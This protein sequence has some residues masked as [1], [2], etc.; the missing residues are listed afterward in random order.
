MGPRAGGHEGHM[1]PRAGGSKVSQ[2]PGGAAVC[3]GTAVGGSEGLIG[4]WATV[5]GGS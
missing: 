1:G 2:V 3:A 5:G 4:G